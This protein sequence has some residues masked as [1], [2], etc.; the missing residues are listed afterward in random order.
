MKILGYLL[1]INVFIV[2]LNLICNNGILL[3]NLSLTVFFVLLYKVVKNLKLIICNRLNFC[4]NNG[5]K[6]KL[7]E[8][9]KD[10]FSKKFYN[11]FLI[12]LKKIKINENKNI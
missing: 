8:I 5:D 2:I 3:T 9:I 7:N 11:I 12:E 6:N 4:K 1:E 10:K